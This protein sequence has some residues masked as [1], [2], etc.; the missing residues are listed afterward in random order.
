MSFLCLQRLMEAVK[1]PWLN[2]YKT[3]CYHG[4]TPGSTRY[5]GST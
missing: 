4:E 1:F 2:E 5:S 3:M